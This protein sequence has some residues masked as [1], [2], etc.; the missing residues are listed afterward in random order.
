MQTFNLCNMT[1]DPRFNKL[2]VDGER[3][4]KLGKIGTEVLAMSGA[5]KRGLWSISVLEFVSFLGYLVFRNLHPREGFVDIIYY[6]FIILELA[7]FILCMCCSYNNSATLFFVELALVSSTGLLL[8]IILALSM[9]VELFVIHATT[10]IIFMFLMLYSAAATLLLSIILF[11]TRNSAEMWSMYAEYPDSFDIFRVSMT[12]SREYGGDASNSID[13]V[14][15]EMLIRMLP[16]H[17]MTF[18]FYV[19]VYIDLPIADFSGWIIAYHIFVLISATRLL[20]DAKNRREAFR[21]FV[22]SVVFVMT[23][24]FIT[25]LSISHKLAP[26]V[27][28]VQL[29]LFFMVFVYFSVIVYRYALLPPIEKTILTYLIVDII[30]LGTIIFEMIWTFYYISFAMAGL[31]HVHVRWN[32]F[33]HVVTVFAAAGCVSAE[34]S[35]M[36]NAQL[37][38]VASLLVLAS[39]LYNISIYAFKL[40]VH[41][42]FVAELLVYTIFAIA[43]FIYL[44]A[45]IF[46]AQGL[47]SSEAKIYYR[48]KTAESVRSRDMVKVL[49]ELK[50]K[51]YYPT[52]NILNV[53]STSAQNKSVITPAEETRSVEK[54]AEDADSKQ[55]ELKSMVSKA[56]ATCMYFL[57]YMGLFLLFII[58]SVGIIYNITCITYQSHGSLWGWVGVLHLLSWFAI[59]VV[60]FFPD[61]FEKAVYSVIIINFLLVIPDILLLALVNASPGITMQWGLFL[62]IDI[63]TAALCLAILYPR[64]ELAF[65]YLKTL[66]S[67]EDRFAG[68]LLEYKNEPQMKLGDE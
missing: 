27:V 29:S 62:I 12:T 53:F 67:M 34:D 2:L 55:A 9:Y 50:L 32:T 36:Y 45:F 54:I 1:D 4:D 17:W 7:T 11:L 25:I 35:L 58:L 8:T 68:E 6:L 39:D 38:A 16:V 61:Y 14:I 20:V 19:L 21:W 31:S 23:M 49:E 44:L 33:L 26:V 30:I 43:P 3:M 66:D 5:L 28:A 63:V 47:T 60:F 41:G 42:V 46:L 13:I 37:M 64:D 56:R 59:M 18:I 40:S 22:L 10:I 57:A 51:D 65:A 24:D 52:L 15:R 48:I